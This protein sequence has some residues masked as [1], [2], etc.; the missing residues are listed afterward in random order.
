MKISFRAITG[1]AVICSLLFVQCKKEIAPDNSDGL[2]SATQTGANTFG[3]ILSTESGGSYS[4]VADNDLTD[5]NYA[6]SGNGAQFKNDTLT[7]GGAPQIGSYFK[8]IQFIVTGTPQQGTIYS[9]DSVSTIAI[10]ATDS[11]CAGVSFYPTTSIAS[12]GIIQLT[13]FDAVNK[14]VSGTFA[15]TFP[16]PDNCD[17]LYVTEGRFDYKYQ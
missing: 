13:K 7:I 17:T 12:S 10:A 16:F 8:G 11:T 3:C 4:F 1:I 2:P 14:I 9:I 6:T 15:C 5:P